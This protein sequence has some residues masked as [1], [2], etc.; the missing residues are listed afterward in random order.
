MKSLSFLLYDSDIGS[1][2]SESLKTNLHL[3][4]HL[5]MIEKYEQSH[6]LSL[7]SNRTCRKI[8]MSATFGRGR[9][10]ALGVVCL[11]QTF[12]EDG[13]NLRWKSESKKRTCRSIVSATQQVVP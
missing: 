11:V 4:Y 9:S 6:M 3:P 12:L 13:A 5:V 8:S 1:H 2:Y 7:S 10:G